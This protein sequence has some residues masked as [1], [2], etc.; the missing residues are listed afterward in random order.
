[1]K[2]FK[3]ILA[4]L[5]LFVI[6]LAPAQQS[7]TLE[8]CRRMA[9][10]NNKQMAIATHNKERAE[11]VSGAAK[12]NFLPRLSAGGT[13]VFNNSDTKMNLQLAGLGEIPLDFDLN[14]I[15]MADVNVE[16]PIYMGGKITS[17]YKMAQAGSDIADL[18][19]SLTE[20]EVLLETDK[21]FWLC[22]QARELLLSAEQYKETVEEFYRVVKN[23]CD[24]GMKSQNDLMK[25]QVQL[26]QAELQLHRAENGLRL[27]RMNLCNII[28]LSLQTDITLSEIFSETPTELKL[29]V[30]IHGRPEYAMLEKQIELK[31]H[32]K[33]YVRSDFL[34][35]IGIMGSYGYIHGTE[36][37]NEQLFGKKGSFSAIVSVRIPLFHWGE[38]A[39]KVQAVNREIS[40]AQLQR[41]DLGEKMELELQQTINSYNEA[42]LEVRLTLEALKQS[43]ENL[44]MS[45]DYYDAG[46]ETISDYLEAQTIW[47]NAQAEYIV[48]KTRQE[49]RKT[50]YLKAIGEI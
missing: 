39:K 24:A 41:D 50:E 11:L 42:L 40:M 5:L 48:A 14:R 27:S 23:A 1:M 32:E 7:L 2:K 18:N 9:L 10:Q 8:E 31:Q 36:F 19:K 17:G 44:R 46:M 45:K 15:Y 38:G 35:Q 28:G 22:V 43:E 47:R 25:V 26:N 34:P 21:A 3:Y 4:T 29:N 13:G 16:Q 12:T 20:D 37:N 49:I 30:S 6:E 33:R